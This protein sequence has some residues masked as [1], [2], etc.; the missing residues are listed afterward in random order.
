MDLLARAALTATASS[1]GGA[2]GQPDDDDDDVD[3]PAVFVPDTVMV[4]E[5]NECLWMYTAASGRIKVKAQNEISAA[6]VVRTLG[7]IEFPDDVCVVLKR[8]ALNPLPVKTNQGDVDIA[9]VEGAADV[10]PLSTN[11]LVELLRDPP[12]GN[13]VIQRYC[14]SKGDRAAFMRVHVK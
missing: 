14:K 5:A 4:L 9:V 13:Y 3:V 6:Q 12:K 8:P 2:H 7:S 10:T 11:G 1:G